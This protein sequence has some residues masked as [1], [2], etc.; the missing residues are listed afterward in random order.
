MLAV[1]TMCSNKVLKIA[2]TNYGH[3]PA[4]RRRQAALA[5]HKQ[6][7][8][9]PEPGPR[10]HCLQND[11]CVLFARSKVQRTGRAVFG[12]VEDTSCGGLG[13]VMVQ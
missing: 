11:G 4:R 1:K 6:E 13:I 9:T 5:Y 3:Q 8:A 7:G 10:K 2:A 12:R